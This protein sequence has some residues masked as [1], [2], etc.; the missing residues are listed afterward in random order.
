MYRERKEFDKEL[1]H[2]VVENDKSQGLQGQPASWRRRGSGV[3]LVQ[4]QSRLKTQ[5]ELMFKFKSK[6]GK[7]KCPSWKAGRQEEF[8]FRVS[9][10]L[11]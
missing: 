5:E 3:V 4:R 9:A 2:M 6:A 7:K 1:A 11:F 10:S 8:S